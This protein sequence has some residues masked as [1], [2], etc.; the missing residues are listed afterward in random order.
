VK[1]STK[2]RGQAGGQPKIW[3]G[4]GPSRP[5]PRTATACYAKESSGAAAVPFLRRIRSPAFYSVGIPSV[6]KAEKT[7]D[8]FT[9]FIISGVTRSWRGFSQG[10]KLN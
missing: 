7:Q 9:S 6:V 2:L 4:H 3:E 5:S 8:C 10:R 1:L